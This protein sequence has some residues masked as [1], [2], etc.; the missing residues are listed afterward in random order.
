MKPGD[1]VVIAVYNGRFI[2]TEDQL[3]GII[4]ETHDEPESLEPRADVLSSVG[5]LK[6]IPNRWMR[7]INEAG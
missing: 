5:L 1:L 2:P 6:S 7:V 3:T 4:I